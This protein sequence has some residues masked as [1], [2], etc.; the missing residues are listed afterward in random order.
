MSLHNIKILL[1]IYF[2]NL[3]KDDYAIMFAYLNITAAY[4]AVEDFNNGI[5]YLKRAEKYIKIH[6]N[7]FKRACNDYR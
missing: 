1:K 5:V 3:L 4:F 7:K 6:Q 2:V